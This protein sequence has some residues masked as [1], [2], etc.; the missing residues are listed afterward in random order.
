LKLQS[1]APVTLP[2]PATLIVSDA[3]HSGGDGEGG[4][5]VGK[6]VEP[7]GREPGEVAEQFE[8]GGDGG[9]VQGCASSQILRAVKHQ[10]REATK[11][12]RNRTG[13][14]YV[15]SLDAGSPGSSTSSRLGAPHRHV[16]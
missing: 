6:V 9:R 12:G 13:L 16:S 5:S 11:H 7:H 8:G 14:S 2:Y 1:P 3:E 4:G 15:S 10:A